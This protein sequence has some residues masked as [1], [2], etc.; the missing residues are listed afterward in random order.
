MVVVKSKTQKPKNWYSNHINVVPPPIQHN[1]ATWSKNTDVGAVTSFKL[2]CNPTKSSS[3]QHELKVHSFD[4]RTVEQF[5][6]W[7]RDLNKLIKGQNLQQ[8]EDKFEMA[9]FNK[10]S[11]QRSRRRWW[12]IQTKCLKG[13]AKHVFLNQCL[14]VKKQHV[15]VELECRQ[16][17]QQVL[18]RRQQKKTMQ[19]PCQRCWFW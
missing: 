4:T 11:T 6:L 13:L 19:L 10:K 2:C 1:R 7:K 8:A 15:K 12:I 14:A 18:S 9:I 17:E 16:Y 3:L 5:I